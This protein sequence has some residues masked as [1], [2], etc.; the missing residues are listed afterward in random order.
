MGNTGK[1]TGVIMWMQQN[2]TKLI[3]VAVIYIVVALIVTG[4]FVLRG[5]NVLAATDATI[6]EK[7]VA[8]EQH[9]AEGD[10]YQKLSDLA[11]LAV[12]TQVAEA[13]VD[14]ALHLADEMICEKVEDR[15]L[16]RV[17]S[18]LVHWGAQVHVQKAIEDLRGQQQIYRVRLGE[19]I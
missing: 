3:A 12:D 19:G 16:Q 2:S 10:H 5:S 8:V 18:D 9:Y 14:E 4:A 13:M 17:L 15:E 6:S 11:T 1:K 7:N